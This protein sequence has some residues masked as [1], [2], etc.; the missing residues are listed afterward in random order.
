MTWRRVAAAATAGVVL[1]AL[2]A[3]AWKAQLASAQR[4]RGA[5][6]FSGATPL[7]GRLVGHDRELPPLA[8]RC[9]N[10][11]EG[12]AAPAYASPLTAAALTAPRVRRGGPP[13]VF[14]AKALCELLREG[15]DP[16]HVMISTAMPRY[17]ITDAQCDDL[18]SFLASR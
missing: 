3:A 9:G 15:I 2:A 18:W 14:G 17:T 12:T 1:A 8:T 6:L 7:P 11:H 4:A 10:C 16:A 13:T 5:A